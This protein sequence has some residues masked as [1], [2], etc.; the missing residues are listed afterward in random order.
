MSVLEKNLQK[1]LELME[2]VFLLGPEEVGDHLGMDDIDSWDSLA[3]VS[4][5]VGVQETFGH[6]MTP[7]E[8]MEVKSLGD[9]KT[10]LRGKGVEI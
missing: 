1:F 10:Y 4:M 5:A 6:H 8:A 7:D 3:T 9:I 2:D